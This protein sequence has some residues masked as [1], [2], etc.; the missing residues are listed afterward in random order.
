[1]QLP[2]P[3]FPFATQQ[4]QKVTMDKK[5]ISENFSHSKKVGTQKISIVN[6]CASPLQVRGPFS[7]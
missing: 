1:M 3:S 6:E 7:M 2:A 4:Q 5:Q